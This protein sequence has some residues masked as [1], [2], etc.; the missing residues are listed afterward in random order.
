MTGTATDLAGHSA[1][2]DSPPVSIDRTAPNVAITG[3][4]FLF[5]T[6]KLRGTTSDALSGVRS[7]EVT[8]KRVFGSGTVVRQADSLTC[9][10]AGELHLDRTAARHRD[11]AGDRP[12][13]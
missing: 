1:T 3:S 7:V 10:T 8:Y 5:G 9:T 12:G 13:D 11:L 2:A 6:Q 4:F